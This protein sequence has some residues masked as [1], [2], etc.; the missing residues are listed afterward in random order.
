[1]EEYLAFV[2]KIGRTVDGKYIYRLDFSMDIDSVWGDYFNEAP[3]GII[4]SLQPD[5]KTLSSTFRADFNSELS[6]AKKSYCFSMQDCIDGILP[7]CFSELSDESMM[8]DDKPFYLKFGEEKETV[9]EKLKSM[10]IEPYDFEEIE[11]DDEH[12]AL[13]NLIEEG[14]EEK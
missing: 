12:D 11:Q 8:K 2:D 4:P 3:S 13:D 14:E 5:K 1:M 9:I 6:L 7:L 10:D